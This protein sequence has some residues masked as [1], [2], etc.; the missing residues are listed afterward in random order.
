MSK[1]HSCAC[2]CETPVPLELESVG[3]CVTHFILS[4]EETCAQMHREIVLRGVDAERHAAVATYITE[5]AQLLAR[6]SSNLRLTDELKRRILS[7]FLCL[8]NLR[9]K[10]DRACNSRPVARPSMGSPATARGAVAAG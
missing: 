6:V 4:I 3:R 8:M 1:P 2:S 5:C 9:E 10:L 7:G